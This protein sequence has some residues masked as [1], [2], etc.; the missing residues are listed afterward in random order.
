MN[1]R[2]G[3]EDRPNCWKLWWSDDSFKSD[4]LTTFSMVAYFEKKTGSTFEN[5]VAFCKDCKIYFP[6]AFA[7]LFLCMLQ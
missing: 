1:F 7:F 5:R 3:Q 4:R 2:V 6:C